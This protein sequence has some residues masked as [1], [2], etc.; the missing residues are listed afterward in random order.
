M[1]ANGPVRVLGGADTGKT[2]VAMH[3][4]KFL[5]EQV[6]NHPGN[7]ILFT[8][9]T[10]NLAEDID[11]NL[12][13]ICA[14]EVKRRI[15]VVN[16]DAWVSEFLK[17]HGYDYNLLASS[18]QAKAY[19]QE[20]MLVA[21]GNLALPQS[22]YEQEWEH[23]IQAQGI[24]KE[25]EYLRAS[26]IGRGQRLS[27]QE[28]RA[29]WPVF[30]EYR[31]ILNRHHVKEF[32]DAI[33]DVRILL[34]TR[35]GIA[36]YQAVIVDEAQDMSAAA[37]KLLRQI[38]PP[39]PERK[40]DLF[41]VGDAHQRIYAHRVVLGRCGIDIRGRSHKLRLNYRTTDEIRKWAV[42]L[43]ENCE[44]DDRDGGRDD[45]KGY[46][47]LL[48]GGFPEVRKLPTFEEEVEVTRESIR[49]LEAEDIPRSSICVVA[50]TQGLLE[51]YK[52]ALNAKDIRHCRI[53]H[54][55]SDDPSKP[56]L[57]TA[58][59]HRVKGLEFDAM[60]IAG[61]NDGIVPLTAATTEVDSDY[62]HIE[63]EIKERSLLYVAA[64]RARR[65]VL[66]TCHGTPSKF[67]SS[68]DIRGAAL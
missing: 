13:K 31:A 4:A 9:F 52:S 34:E 36:E 57:R 38:I 43:L 21:P 22:F 17:K 64:T 7:K 28:R 32:V 46:R 33:R 24:S 53:Q 12:A 63:F 5:A 35:T 11:A 20:A 48:H 8:T 56:D 10:R 29:I 1:Q 51:Q 58:T 61:I 62:A 54:Q 68:L 60:I 41:I 39:A 40:N 18:A 26:R 44:I 27:R 45:N 3:R 30:E 49:Q 67:I 14:I 6:F 15:R 66:I 19:W 42:A 37:F 47:S 2:V 65:H 16:L 25:A 23:V 55:V 50:R 59:M